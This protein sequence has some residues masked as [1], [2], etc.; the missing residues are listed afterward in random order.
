MLNALTVDVE[1][2]FMVSAYA[3]VIRFE[4]WHRYESHV[5]KNTLAI[6]DLLDEYKVG[7]TF[8]VLGWVAENY[9]GL[10][11]EIHKRGHDIDSHGYNHRLVYDLS[12]EEFRKDTRMAKKILEDITGEPVLGYR[13]T[14][15]SITKESLWSLDIL[16]EEGFKYDSSIFPISHDR[17]GYPGFDR[18]PLVIDNGGKG[19]ILEIPPSTVKLFGRNIPVAGGGYLRLFPIQ[20][21][22]WG[23][24]RIYEKEGQPAIVYF[25]PWE[26]DQDLPRLNGSWVSAFRQHV[27]IGK[28]EDRIRRLL[29]NFRFTTLRETFASMLP[30]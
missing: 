5:V 11:K 27:N 25:H 19:K 16:M 24:R 21:I 13:A 14:S 26:I 29:E 30:E 3:D 17:Y 23:L 20:F 8:F 22:E 6:L 1:D 12:P 2:Y 7:A 18:F 28:T 4:D 10:V 15:W 9:P